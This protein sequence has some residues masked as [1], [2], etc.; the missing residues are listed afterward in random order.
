MD[1]VGE[2]EKVLMKLMGNQ[3]RVGSPMPVWFLT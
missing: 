2:M 3:S 1:Q